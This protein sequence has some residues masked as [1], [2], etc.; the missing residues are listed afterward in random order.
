MLF[1]TPAQEVAARVEGD[2]PYAEVMANPDAWRGRFVRVR[3]VLGNLEANRLRQPIG[4]S[5]D[6]YRGVIAQP[7]GSEGVVFDMLEGDPRRFEMRRST[8]E[9]VG[10]FYRTARYEKQYEDKQGKFAEAPYLLVRSLEPWDTG[11]LAKRT[12]VD[13]GNKIDRILMVL[14]ALAVA[15]L[16]ARVLFSISK[17]TRRRSPPSGGLQEALRK[18]QQGGKL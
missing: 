7:D 9:V 3:G 17:Q 13:E 4:N 15:Y 11:D 2:L 5:Q 12:M 8:V 16:V 6:V 10:L 18:R 1:S 14:M